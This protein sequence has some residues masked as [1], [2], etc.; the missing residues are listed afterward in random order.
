MCPGL[1]QNIEICTRNRDVPV[2]LMIS[3]A[4]TMDRRAKIAHTVFALN[5]RPIG[6]VY[7]LVLAGGGN[8]LKLA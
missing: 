3:N 7:T 2:D 4:I 8:E 6:R 1:V 5:R